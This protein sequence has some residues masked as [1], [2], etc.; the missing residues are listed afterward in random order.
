MNE[1]QPTARYQLDNHKLFWLVRGATVGL[2][3]VAAAFAA[4]IYWDRYHSKSGPAPAE[5]DIN[6]F[7]AQVREDPGDLEARISMAA[8]YLENGEYTLASQQA[9]LVL[10]LYPET[11]AA[12]LI[13]G[14][15]SAEMEDYERAVDHL[16]QFVVQQEAPAR[17]HVDPVLSAALYYL[18]KSHLSLNEP[19]E[20]IKVFEEV[21]TMERTDADTIFLLGQAY[22]ANGEPQ[23]AIERF[24]E[25][26]KY[27]PTFV[28]AYQSLANAYTELEMPFHAKYA[29]GMAAYA[30]GEY[31][32]GLTL[33][34]QSVIELPGFVPAII[35]LGLSYEAVGDY[36]AAMVEINTALSFEP[37]NVTASYAATRIQA[38][39]DAENNGQK[40]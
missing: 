20:A 28:E 21:L 29:R 18:G 8:V 40:K 14:V 25:A 19:Q 11:P 27:V 16:S 23:L 39:I 3:V 7:E 12:L 38:A 13:S 10:T 33:L 31:L 37:D 34:Q 36:E 22:L 35:G 2:F 15:A 32:S 24:H 17:N 4:T 30:A 9:A 1:A 5:I 6:K 26:V